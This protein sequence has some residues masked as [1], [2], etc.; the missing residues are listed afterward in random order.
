M[1]EEDAL[2]NGTHVQLLMDSPWHSLFLGSR[3]IRAELNLVTGAIPVFIASVA[4]LLGIFL[5][6][7]LAGYAWRNWAMLGIFFAFTLSGSIVARFPSSLIKDLGDYT[8]DGSHLNDE[9]LRTLWNLGTD[10]VGRM[11]RLV[12]VS[13]IQDPFSA[14]VEFTT[15]RDTSE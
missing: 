12:C 14:E 11:G 15:F 7:L 2:K 10:D 1:E 6:E 9:K 13:K 5:G 3:N 4:L 8:K